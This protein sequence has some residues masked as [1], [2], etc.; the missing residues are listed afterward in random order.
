[1]IYALAGLSQARLSSPTGKVKHRQLSS[2]LS[3]VDC[4][5]RILAGLK[6][7]W[8][9]IWARFA[10]E[11]FQSLIR[12]HTGRANL[13]GPLTRS[14][15]LDFLLRVFQVPFGQVH[16]P[17]RRVQVRMPHQLRH[18]EYI[19]AGFDGPSSIGMPKIVEP[20]WR[21]DCAFP[22][23]PLAFLESLA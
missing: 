2:L 21:L 23:R 9:H 11:Q 13:Q 6:G 18:T 22:Q 19:D 5:Y 4:K 3:C 10:L 17:L 8:V 16:V 12:T 20:E 1:L 15:A 7:G 14:E